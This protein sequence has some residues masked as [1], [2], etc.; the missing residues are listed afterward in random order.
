MLSLLLAAPMGFTPLSAGRMSP[1]RAGPVISSRTAAA[2]VMDVNNDALSAIASPLRKWQPSSAADGSILS[3][4]PFEVAALFGVIILVGVAGLIRQ[5]GVLSAAAPTVGLGQTR[6]DL[7]PA[8]EEAEEE[9]AL[10]QAEQEKKYFAI[11]AQEQAEKRGGDSSAR[12]KK[13]KS[14]KR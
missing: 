1:L 6:D 11:L 2:P 13:K 14:K 8:A 10:T 5:S 7:A 12:K 3:D 9:A 4:V